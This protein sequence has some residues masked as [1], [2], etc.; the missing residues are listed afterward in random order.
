M[1]SIYEASIKYKENLAYPSPSNI[2]DFES[3]V[4]L[5]LNEE[6]TLVLWVKYIP[7]PISNFQYLLLFQLSSFEK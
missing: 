4:L 5:Q 1:L 6:K 2:I 7:H 3:V